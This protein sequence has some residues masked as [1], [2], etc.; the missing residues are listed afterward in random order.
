MSQYKE[1][2][3]IVG[4]GL[5]GLGCA[6]RLHQSGKKFKIISENIGGRV[7]TSPDG[8][9]NYGAYYLTKDCKNIL[10]H[11]RIVKKMQFK[12]YHFHDGLKHYHLIS[13][14]VAPFLPALARLAWD[15]RRFR[16]RFNKLREAAIDRS[17]EELIEADPLLKKYYHQR[18]G[19]YIK[20]KKLEP[21]VEKYLQPVLWASFFEDP[22]NVPTFIFMQTMLPLIVPS[23][24]FKLYFNKM[25]KGFRDNIVED[26]VVKVR[27]AKKGYVLQTENGDQYLGKKLVMATPMTVTNKLIDQQPI[28]GTTPVSY[29]H[30]NGEPRAKY[31]YPGFQFFPLKEQAAISKEVDGTYLYFY[32]GKNN[33]SKFFSS[34]EIITKKNWKPALMLRG[35]RYINLNP[36][37]N[38]FLA[39][40]HDVASTE[41]AF[42]NG[43][44][45]AKL[46][47]K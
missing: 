30:I 14:E 42:I 26:S 7:E 25:T 1:E 15:L 27:P 32:R 29:L 10:P 16:T 9:V 31:D 11:R 2:I 40:D 45:T 6:R 24:S 22:A 17:R 37:E 20:Q 3:I 46:V 33:V 5:A 19:E 39:N 12:E 47:M 18:A 43:L 8:E 38:L 41:D 44:Y 34:L 36:A 23:Y 4:G 13:P 21:L 35:D 28:K